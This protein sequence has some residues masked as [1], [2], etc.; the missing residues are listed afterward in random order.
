MMFLNLIN[1]KTLSDSEL[2]EIK[3]HGGKNFTYENREFREKLEKNED[4]Y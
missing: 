2:E 1:S 4:F 3:S